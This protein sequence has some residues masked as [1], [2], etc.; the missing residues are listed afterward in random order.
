MP[1]L[2][3]FLSSDNAHISSSIE[4]LRKEIGL[5]RKEQ[6]KALKLLL[7][8]LC[9]NANQLIRVSR[10]RDAISTKKGNPL[11]IGPDSLRS[12]L[13]AL[14]SHGYVTQD[15]GSKLEN[16]QTTI[17]TTTK[18]I[19]WFQTNGWT[20][21]DIGVFDGQYVTLRLNKDKRGFID[22]DDTDYSKWLSSE[23][24]GYSNLLN[25][26]SIQL[27]DMNGEI[28]KEYK[29]LSISR[30]F[31]KHK[32]HPING[33]F[34]FGGRMAPP[35]V[36]LS[37]EARKRIIING[38]R[39]V[40]IDRPASHINAMYEVITGKPYQHGYPYDLSVDG[41]AVPKHIVKHLSAFMQGSSNARGTAIR[42]G[43]HYKREA[44]KPGASAQDIDNHLEWLSFKKGVNSSVIIYM[45]LHK[46]SLVRDSYLRGKQYGDKIQCWESDIVFEVVIE[47]VKR[48]IPVL[49]VYDSFIVQQSSLSVLEE[50]MEKVK[51]I[52]RR[53]LVAL[54]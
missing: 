1:K 12:A 44:S 13:N 48:G 2:N 21:D 11:R 35:W 10:K 5:V 33:E 25:Q 49:T 39:T 34:L 50:L 17:I 52:D 32:H 8:N 42:V 23:L 31:I 37:K 29:N 24:E 15:I 28:E 6:T 36:N 18:L 30:A 3:L 9:I 19:E 43:K 46:H 26:S 54:A 53:E 7:C 41:R 14:D 45:F 40:E 16:K 38:E 47:L 51:F 22:F 4:S 20:E 27:L